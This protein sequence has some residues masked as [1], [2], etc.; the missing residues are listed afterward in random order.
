M[1]LS[2]NA[3][4]C[5]ITS[6]KKM[7]GDLPPSSVVDGMMFCAAY[8]MISRPVAVS[9]VKAIFAIRLLVASAL[10]ISAPGP[11]TMLM[12][13]GRD[14]VPD[15]L[16]ELEDR[17]RRRARRLEHRAV[18]RGERGRHLPGPHQQREVERDDLADDAQ[19]LVEVVGDR[20]LVDLGDRPLLAADHRREV[21]EVVGGQRDVGGARLADRLAV[22]V[23]LGDRE[24]LEVL[25]DRVGDTVEHPCAL[26]R[27]RLAPR[28][29]GSVRGVE[30]QLDVGRAGVGHLRERLAGR[31]RHVVAVLPGGGRDPVAA[32]EVLI[33]RS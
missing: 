11:L 9:P 20:V 28:V 3:S 25:L 12:H 26:G 23:A 4:S 31:R 2:R 24:R 16:G 7:F 13:A 21:A 1:A 29:L 18:A 15:Q 5:A 27:R 22:V 8:C 32:D 14:D 10:P 30:R 33:A 19:R 17:P 6:A